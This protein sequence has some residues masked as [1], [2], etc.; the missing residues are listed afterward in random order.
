MSSNHPRR[1]ALAGPRTM[2]HEP[3]ETRE[4]GPGEARLRSLYSGI[5]HGT[6]MAHYRG[7]ESSASVEFDPE[8]RV[9][10]PSTS[11]GSFPMRMGYELVSEVV[12]VADGVIG[13]AVG[14]VVHTSG[15]HCTESVI[16]VAEESGSDFYPL[17]RVPS[18]TDP[19][20]ALYFSLAAVALY[21]IHDAGI[22][23]GDSVA[24]YGLGA[25]GQLVLQMARLSGAA[26]VVGVDPLPERRQWAERVGATATVDPTDESTS[27]GIAVKQG[28]P[29]VGDGTSVRDSLRRGADIA[30]ETSGSYDALREAVRCVAVGGRVVTVGGFWYQPQGVTGALTGEWH[31]NRPEMR[32]SMGVWNCPHRDHPRW[33]QQR[34]MHTVARLFDQ[35]SL[36]VSGYPMKLFPFDDAA[37]AYEFVDQRPAE[38]L[39]VG[40]KY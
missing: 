16:D 38:A 14:D 27:A 23:L 35:G 9:F 29:K 24:V 3:I 32:S 1:V 30:I 40:L 26:H 34:I 7:A 37:L 28:A 22:K 39:K 2:A 11:A 20:H 8:L 13:V 19:T 31:S 17:V 4:L 6:E 18:S 5:S 10:R 15:E 12:E 21:A 36:D 33:D 25:V